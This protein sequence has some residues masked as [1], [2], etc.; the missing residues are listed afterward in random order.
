MEKNRLISINI[1]NLWSCFTLLIVIEIQ[2]NAFILTKLD[3]VVN[4][5][6]KLF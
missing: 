4:P 3:K 2:F 1:N 6:K 5:M